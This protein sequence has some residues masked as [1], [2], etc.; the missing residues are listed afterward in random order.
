MDDDPYVVERG[1]GFFLVDV[2]GWS[3]AHVAVGALTT[4][5]GL[6]L[7]APHRWSVRFAVVVAAGSVVVHAIM[8][9]FEPVWSVIVIA[10]VLAALRLLWLSRRLPA[11]ADDEVRAAGRPSR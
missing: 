9:P 7:F 2:T 3:W 10:V 1:E 11:P 6:L 4:F 8:V 5:I